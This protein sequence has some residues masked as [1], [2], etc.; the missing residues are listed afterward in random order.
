MTAADS[1][2]KGGSNGFRSR[3]NL[4]VIAASTAIKSF[5]GG[6]I[7]SYVALVFVELGGNAFTFGVIAAL[8]SL[9]GCITFLLGGLIADYY[10][11]KR[12]MIIAAFYGAFSVLLFAV[13]KDWR[14]FASVYIVTT[15]ASISGPASSATVA[16]SLPPKKRATGIAS[17]QVIASLPVVVAPLIGGYIMDEIGILDGFRLAA[18]FTAA[19]S[20]IS[21]LVL[22]IFLRETWQ[23]PDKGKLR[24]CFK[25]P[26]QLSSSLKG[27]ICSYALV[28]FA[29]GAVAS[30]YLLYAIQVIGLTPLQWAPIVSAQFL[31]TLI[32]IP[33]ARLSD[34]IG[35]RKVMIVSVLA[36]A[37]CAVMFTLSGSFLQALISI[38]LVTATGIF[39]SPAYEALQADLTPKATRGRIIALWRLTTSLATM[40]GTIAGGFLFE[41]VDPAL[42]FYL[43]CIA[44]V[45]AALVIVRFVREP[46]KKE[47]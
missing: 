41:V 36:C 20:L 6:L 15:F 3:G 44:E 29:N 28:A 25:L 13:T 21:A 39:Y 26:Q 42:P 45:I 43:F 16:D 11:R 23:K 33:G 17:L 40:P 1:Q 2:K 24:D 10:G 27:L 8:A 31:I 12:I 7:N 18:V 19:F 32:K 4:S 9:I 47:P 30:Y 37:P 14:L 5:G 38:L 35:K 22:F 34:N 46:D